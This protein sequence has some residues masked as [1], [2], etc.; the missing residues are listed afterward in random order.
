MKENNDVN[1]QLKRKSIDVSFWILFASAMFFILTKTVSDP[2]LWGHVRFGLDKIEQGTVI[3]VDPYSYVSEGGEW[4]N[5]EWLAEVLFGMAWSVGGTPGLILLKVFVGLLLAGV[6][7]Y[8]LLSLNVKDTVAASLILILGSPLFIVFFQMIR[9]Q[10]FTFLF[11]AVTLLIIS[12]AEK[13]SYTWLW[14]MPAVMVLWTNLHGGFIAG[15]GILGGWFFVH[16]YLNSEKSSAFI[17]PVALSLAAPLINPYGTKL[18][19]FLLRT[20][21][22]PRPEIADWNPLTLFSQFG[23]IYCL[24]LGLSIVGLVF[25][26]KERNPVLI[27]L[28]GITALLPWTAMRHITLLSISSIIF[29]GEH[30]ASAGG[31]LFQTESPAFSKSRFRNTF[32]IL[33]SIIFISLSFAFH[34]WRIETTWNLP[35]TAVEILKESDISGNM[36]TQFDWGE[37]VIWHL[38]PQVK[39]SL[40]GRRETVYSEDAYKK[41][42][43][44]LYAQDTWDALLKEYPTDIVLIRPSS[45]VYKLIKLHSDWLLVFEDSDSA[46]F[47]NKTSSVKT[48]LLTSATD[49][50]P[51]KADNYFP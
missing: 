40:D 22:I 12:K 16:L 41:S 2:D 20:T 32:H 48:A 5:H 21:T 28:F 31:R 23:F 4:I 46:L 49:F 47:V 3:R 44:F 37:Y 11:F 15:W 27:F 35:Y 6:F 33:G 36:A 19:I 18:I 50:K 34:F 7:V 1:L 17:P 39:V 38:G 14:A 13:G 51:S 43:D 45:P 30:I 24:I 26:L 10:I 42:L 29:M 8:Y 9:S 25:S